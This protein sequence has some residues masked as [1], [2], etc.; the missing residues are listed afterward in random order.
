MAVMIRDERDSDWDAITH[1]TAAAFRDCQYSGQT[2]PFIVKAL[3]KA[4]VM[5]ISLVAEMDGRVV[6]HVAFSPV[7]ISDGSAGWYG[8]GPISV[9][10]ELQRR[11]IGKKLMNEGLRRLKAMG[12]GGCVLVGD[13][14]YYVRFGFKNVPGLTHE[15]VPAEVTLALA[16]GERMARG[17][18]KF[19]E[20]FGA[21]Q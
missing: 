3:R 12:A 4:G 14:A 16:F 17:E 2:E 21:E 8:V 10:P 1:V 20:G 19:H 9:L 5:T 11:G 7:A 6:G 13:P 18:M 15:G